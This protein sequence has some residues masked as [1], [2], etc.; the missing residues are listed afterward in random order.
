MKNLP[1][2]SSPSL[3]AYIRTNMDCT[4]HSH[5]KGLLTASNYLQIMS[6]LRHIYRLQIGT[7]GV[8]IISYLHN[9]RYLPLVHE[10]LLTVILLFYY[11]SHCSKIK[12]LA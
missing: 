10:G 4:T 11:F 1:L 2:S 7:R 12:P 3:L 8:I 5:S 6:Y 9:I